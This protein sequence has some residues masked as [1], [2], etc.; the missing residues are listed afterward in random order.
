MSGPSVD[1]A[2]AGA[3]S[4]NRDQ[5]ADLISHSFV[6]LALGE[7]A[8]GFR[9]SVRQTVL[10]P[11]ITLTD[12]RTQG[13]SVVL[14]TER[15]VRCEP[16]EDYLLSLQLAGP[17]VVVQGD[18]EVVLRPGAG[19]LYDTDRPYRLVFPASTREIVLQ[20]PRRMLRERLD[21]LADLYGRSLPGDDP[22]VRVLAGFLREL[23]AAAPVVDSG[24]LAE[25]GSSAVDL[26]ATALRA[27]AAQHTSASGRAAL[28]PAMRDYVAAHLADRDLTPS[29]L[30]RRYGVSSRYLAEVF[31]GIGSSPAAY[32]RCERLKAAYRLL[33]DPRQAHRQVAVIAAQCGFSD[34]TT[35]TRAFVRRYGITPA[36]VRA[37]G[38]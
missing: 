18:R 4:G 6:P 12:V 30:A 2:T 7:A 35:F 22:A 11:G 36:Q 24:R 29:L 3:G 10:L 32:I 34:R 17:G 21:D 23:V 38:S 8:A 13:R 20:V 14:R 33:S 1:T 19:A 37:G 9:G 27:T 28:L 31:A 25:F 26:I 5:W 15:L 16:R